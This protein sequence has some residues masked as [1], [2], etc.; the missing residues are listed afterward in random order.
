MKIQGV[1]FR[2]LL[3]FTEM[4]ESPAAATG[5]LSSYPSGIP[6]ALWYELVPELWGN[7]FKLQNPFVPHP[8]SRNLEI[9]LVYDDAIAL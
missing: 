1:G 3:R 5:C 6:R 4:L 8:S 2:L 9:C 7:G